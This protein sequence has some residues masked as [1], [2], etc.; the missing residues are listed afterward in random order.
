MQSNTSHEP[1]SLLSAHQ[2]AALLQ[3]ST[4]TVWRLLSSGELIEPLRV[5]GNTRWRR[6]ELDAW[7][8]AGCPPVEPGEE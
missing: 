4:R 5:R 2:V 3:V 6:A 7:I 1:S 8:E